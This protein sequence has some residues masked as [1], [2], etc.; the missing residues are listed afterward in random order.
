MLDTTAV[1]SNMQLLCDNVAVTAELVC[2]Y[3]QVDRSRFSHFF[4]STRQ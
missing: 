3:K 4:S 1:Y 2:S